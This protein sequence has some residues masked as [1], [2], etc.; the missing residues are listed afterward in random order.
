M[1]EVSEPLGVTGLV[2]PV[3][4]QLVPLVTWWVSVIQLLDLVVH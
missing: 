1:K 4:L 3:E 2:L